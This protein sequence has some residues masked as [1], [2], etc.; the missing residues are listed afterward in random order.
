MKKS[1]GKSV[2]V[3]F[4]SDGQS[5]PVLGAECEYV[6]NGKA[7]EISFL[8]KNLCVFAEVDG[9]DYSLL[10]GDYDLMIAK[11]RLEQLSSFYTPK[12][13]VSYLDFAGYLNAESNGR[14]L[15]EYKNK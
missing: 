9:V 10:K 1:F 7:V 14:L 3:G 4:Y 13:F 11:D 2:S 12:I 8:D 5:L 15:F 6:L